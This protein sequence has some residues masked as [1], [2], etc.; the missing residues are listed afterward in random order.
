MGVLRIGIFFSN[1]LNLRAGHWGLVGLYKGLIWIILYLI[2][3][4]YKYIF[5]Y[6]FSL[7]RMHGLG[8]NA[9]VRLSA[10]YFFY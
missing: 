5:F 6:F 9:R 8:Y 2:T 1:A 10:G 7:L 3:Q 4:N